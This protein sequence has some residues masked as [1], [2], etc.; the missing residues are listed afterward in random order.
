MRKY[1]IILIIFLCPIGVLAY[2]DSVILGG[3]TIGIEIKSDGVLVVGFYKIEGKYNKSN[4]EILLGDYITH[5]NEE[6][7]DSITG[8]TNLIEKYGDEKTVN[9]T[10]KRLDNEF[11]TKLNIVLSDGSY[12]TGLYVK[13]SVTGIGTLTYIDPQTS[14]FGGLG[15]E[16]IE[17]NTRNLIDV[18][19]GVIF[20]NS[21]TSI[22]KSSSGTPGSKNAKFYYSTVYGE[23]YENTKYGIYGTYE[24][25]LVDG[26][27]IEVANPEE[28][29]I[30]PAYIY[31]VIDGE[32]VEKFDIEI[33][34]INDDSDI[35]NLTIEIT[36]E[37][38]I[39]ASGGVV[40]G[41]SGSPIVQNNKIVG[42]VTHVIVD[43][44]VT[45]Y[46]LFIT[47]MLEEGEN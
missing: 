29:K 7:V 23:I 4:P 8:L 40:Q 12:K 5:I 20:R 11:N 38:L 30:G 18:Y 34:K 24:K 15:H 9:V 2:S 27:L 1:I 28:I 17:S 14:I 44:P 13:E 25:D 42:A 36:D 33:I 39:S 3:N 26:K 31:T 41:M 16:V 37:E 43:N 32:K 45:G 35:K 22:D 46:G 6:K 10:Y 21:I 19:S 47:T